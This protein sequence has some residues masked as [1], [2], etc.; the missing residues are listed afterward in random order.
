MKKSILVTLCYIICSKLNAQTPTQ[1][2]AGNQQIENFIDLNNGLPQG[3]MVY[4]NATDTTLGTPHTFAPSPQ[5]WSNLAGAFKN[6]ASHLG[7]NGGSSNAAQNNSNFRA[8]GIR[9]TSSFGDPGAAFT[10]Q[11]DN[12]VN[13]VNIELQLNH[14]ILSPQ[15]RSTRW[16]TQYSL[17]SGSSW[18][19]IGQY[20][21]PLLADTTDWGD[22]AATYALGSDASN[23]S[24]NIYIRIASLDASTGGG[25][26]DSYAID[27]V[28][29]HWTLNCSSPE[30]PSAFTQQNATF[31]KANIEWNSSDCADEFMLVATENTNLTATP[32]GNGSSYVA[33]DFGSGT[34]IAANE[35]VVY[36]GTEVSANVTGLFPATD[37]TIGL[38]AR[39][40]SSWAGPLTTSIST[41]TAGRM[42]YTGQGIPGEWNDLNNW[43]LNRTPDVF[44]TVVVD[45]S[46]ESGHYTLTLPNS[47]VSVRALYLLPSD[48]VTLLLP[49]SNTNAP[50]LEI[51][52]A[53][54][55]LVIGN[56]AVFINQSGASSGTGWTAQSWVMRGGGSYMHDVNRATVGLLNTLYTSLPDFSAGNWIF[57][58]NFSTVPSFT[59][60]TYPSLSLWGS[61]QPL[62]FISGNPLTIEGDLRLASGTSYNFTLPVNA[63][64][65]AVIKGDAVFSY[66]N[67]HAL[68]ID[69]ADPQHWLIS[70]TG[71]CSIVDGSRLQV[72]NDLQISGSISGDSIN[73]NPTASLTINP[74]G[75]ITFWTYI[76]DGNLHNDGRVILPANDSAYAQMLHSSSSGNGVIEQRMHLNSS[77]AR[78]YCLGSPSVAPISSLADSGT[79]F[80]LN[81]TQTSPVFYW[82]AAN[83]QYSLPNSP[84]DV[85]QPGRGY[86]VFAGTTS[87]GTFTTNVPGCI[88]TVGTLPSATN[89]YTPLHHGQLAQGQNITVQG[90]EDGWNL[91]AN[92]YPISY[93]WN[94]HSIPVHTEGTIYTTNKHNDGFIAIGTTETDSTRYLPPLQGFWIRTQQTLT[95]GT[96]DLPFSP[97]QRKFNRQNTLRRTQQTHPRFKFTFSDIEGHYDAFTIGFHPSATNNFDP[98]YDGYKRKNDSSLGS[99]WAMHNQIA[100]ALLYLPPLNNSAAIPLQFTTPKKGE[101]Y[102]FKLSNHYENTTTGVW[103]ED[104][105]LN[106]IR[107]LRLENHTFSSQMDT[108]KGRYIL[109]IGEQPTSTASFENQQCRIWWHQHR[110]YVETQIPQSI[111]ITSMHGKIVQKFQHAGD[112]KME[113]SLDQ[114]TAGVYLIQHQ[115]GVRKIVIR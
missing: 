98:N 96:T 93:D 103:L 79:H 76:L 15:G 105:H 4:E 13:R 111:H 54:T 83:G 28:Q 25:S 36:K 30:L 75:E 95:S 71:S 56:H 84:A 66:T 31:D 63:R 49:S 34:A 86:A 104:T 62:T 44:D 59:N 7:L 5:S 27:N 80:N 53:D 69:G 52:A 47:P 17:D 112:G 23:S 61:P 90:E 2:A 88:K 74:E 22:S 82:D 97:S 72:N 60:R 42:Y 8:L 41:P 73:S 115:S 89:V 57:G 113:Y 33:D 38:Y 29:L 110:L 16:T 87:N 85:M 40:N 78:W 108:T 21:T 18:T 45:N 48:S 55:G 114:L 39:R 46:F 101:F 94:G 65:D 37:Y 50:G 19:T 99:V 64:G 6:F 109:H 68:T 20:D 14:L 12:T 70:G 91:V 3:W 11:I 51:L 35:Y 107:N 32:A 10:W 92:P 24:T 106:L 100:Y 77:S 1:P 43:S 81:S 67:N 102:S 26:R 9:Q 58:P